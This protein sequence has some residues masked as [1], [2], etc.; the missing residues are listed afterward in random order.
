MEK[1]IVV[2]DADKKQCQE[3][4]SMLDDRNYEATPMHSMKNLT[5]FIQESPCRVLILD[6]DTIPVDKNLFR[7]LKRS[8]PSLCILG[9]SSRAFHPELEE[10]MTKHIYACISKPVDEEELVFWVKSLF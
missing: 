6:M 2:L 8:K 4:C 3:I 7:K 1:E 10:A 9:L 5:E